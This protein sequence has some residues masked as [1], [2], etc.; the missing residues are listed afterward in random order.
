M[1]I[2]ELD[3]WRGDWD[4]PSVDRD[5]LKV[6]AYAQFAG[7]PIKIYHERPLWRNM[8]A[9]FP[10]FHSDGTVLHSADDIVEHLK[11]HGFDADAGLTDQQRAD[12]LA[13]SSLLEEKL[14]PAL[15]HMWWMDARNY[16]ELS[17]PWFAKAV[18]FPFNYFIPGQ[19]QRS[20]ET[21]LEVIRGGQH[22]EDGE[23]AARVTKDAKF[24]LN[25]LSE[26]LGNGEFFFGESPTSMDAMVFSYLA[27]LIKVPFPSNSL[28]IHCKACDNLAKFCSRILQ[29]YFPP[30]PE[31]PPKNSTAP[32]SGP[33]AFDE[34]YK[35]RNQVLSV[36]F[37][38]AAM[39]AY[40]LL[41]GMI[42]FEVVHEDDFDEDGMVDE[43]DDYQAQE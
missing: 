37:A 35:R 6:M 5:C 18:H 43:E 23:L 39:V 25:L 30:D 27:P 42:R 41:S 33:E 1:A 29:R 24:C 34:P 14:L 31:A 19:L 4:L 10:V 12:I 20:A 36:L 7:A 3:C 13:F 40:A 26:R 9:R 8:T 22:L 16:V 21:K 11:Q 32:P 17:R 28:Q 2:M 38:T 15:L